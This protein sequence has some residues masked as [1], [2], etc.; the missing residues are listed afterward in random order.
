VSFTEIKG[1]RELVIPGTPYV[2]APT[3]PIDGLADN[4][5]AVFE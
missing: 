4:S 1:T 5:L 3:R 2:V